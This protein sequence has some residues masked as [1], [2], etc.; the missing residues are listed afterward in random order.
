M[1]RLKREKQQLI[2]LLCTK[3]KFNSKKTI[4]LQKRNLLFIKL[5][6]K[7]YTFTLAS[8]NMNLKNSE[9][10]STNFLFTTKGINNI[11]IRVHYK[12]T[13]YINNYEKL[14]YLF[15]FKYFL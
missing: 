10:E 8:R 3:I 11:R 5:F 7:F 14:Y 1:Q 9:H 12:Y 13:R 4:F 2:L 6:S 15:I